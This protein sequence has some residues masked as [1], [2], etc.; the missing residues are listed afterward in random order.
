MSA[1]ISS[2]RIHSTNPVTMAASSSARSQTAAPL[3]AGGVPGGTSW[4]RPCR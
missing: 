4:H 1:A 2:E 3:S